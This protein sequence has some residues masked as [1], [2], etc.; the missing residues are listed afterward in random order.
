MERHLL[1]I[2]F[3]QNFTNFNHVKFHSEDVI[4][5]IE[6]RGGPKF[7]TATHSYE[8]LPTSVGKKVQVYCVQIEPIYVIAR[9]Q[10]TAIGLVGFTLCFV[11]Y[12]DLV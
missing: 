10:I 1:T 8:P 4:V 3:F 12:R 9:C 6:S 2:L 11:Q 5:D 7:C